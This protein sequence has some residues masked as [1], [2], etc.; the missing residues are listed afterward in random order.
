MVS[1]KRPY[2]RLVVLDDKTGST[3]IEVAE[4]ISADDVDT[5]E[6]LFAFAR[7]VESRLRGL[8]VDRAIVRRADFPTTATKRDAPRL[9]LLTEGA[10]TSAARAAVVDTRLGMGKELAHW[11][12]KP[13]ASLDSAG[14]A[15]VSAAN[16]HSKY[17]EAAAAALA[18][19]SA[20]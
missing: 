16:Q 7:G 11:Y 17:A 13:K 20:P 4:E 18:G 5:V 19:L 14:A 1:P 9:R 6:Q 3:A 2:L 10:A 8:Q 12:G 15:L